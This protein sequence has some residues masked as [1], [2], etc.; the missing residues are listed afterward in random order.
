MLSRLNL[1]HQGQLSKWFTR[2]S[3]WG[4][5]TTVHSDKST[6][7]T[8]SFIPRKRSS[9][10]VPP[11]SSREQTKFTSHRRHLS[12]IV[13]GSS[14][15]GAVITLRT[16][17]YTLSTHTAHKCWQFHYHGTVS[18]LILWC[19]TGNSLF[20][21]SGPPTAWPGSH[22]LFIGRISIEKFTR[23]FC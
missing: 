18:L 9:P 14:F 20:P 8:K 23:C 11:S 13:K 17:L 19:G 16:A 1:W 22:F 5:K 4:L 7:S 3:S 12:S 2:M 6:T 10:A 15:F 21:S